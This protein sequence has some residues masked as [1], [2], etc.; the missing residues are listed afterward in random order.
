MF[1]R[2]ISREGGEK[3]TN[4]PVDPGGVTKFGISQRANPTIDVKNL[5]YEKA[6]LFY[7][8]E[9]FE[10]N[11]LHQLPKVLQEVVFDFCVHS[12]SGTAIRYLQKIL[13]VQQDGV[14]GS[15]TLAAISPNNLLPILAAY[16]RE[17]V[18]FLARQVVNVP[19]KAKYLVGW[20][21]RVLSL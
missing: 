3:L 7:V 20:L 10:K 12:G 4:D 1:D 16:Q 19:A 5:T 9:I 11:N 2:L 18:L 14:I 21:S 15:A 17:R 8:K 6:K 13:G